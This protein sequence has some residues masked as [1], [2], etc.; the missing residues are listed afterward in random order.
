M[1]LQLL[2]LSQFA[3]AEPTLI[4]G[5]VVSI[6]ERNTPTIL[7]LANNVRHKIRLAGINAP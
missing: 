3:H 2:F 7:D 5:R 4:S 6:A 1:G